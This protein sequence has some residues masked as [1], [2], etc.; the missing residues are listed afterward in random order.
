MS[1]IDVKLQKELKGIASEEEKMD[2]TSWLIIIG[3]PE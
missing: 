2:N 1:L 3:A